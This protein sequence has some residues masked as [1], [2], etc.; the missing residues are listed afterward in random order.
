[1]MV[2]AGFISSEKDVQQAYGAVLEASQNNWNGKIGNDMECCIYAYENLEETLKE[3]FLDICVFCQGRDWE[4]L[5][6]IVGE[7]ELKMLEDRALV[8][9]DVKSMTVRV[10]DVMLAIGLDKKGERF[11][12]TRASDFEKFSKK[13]NDQ[14]QKIKGIWSSDDSNLLYVPASKLD[15]MHRSLRVVILAE[16]T[17]VAGKCT[18]IFKELVIF[19]EILIFLLISQS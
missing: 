16:S 15:S 14:L 13:D 8:T 5:S 17:K 12:F 2:V 11:R 1:M 19:R 10:H 18:E 6:K 9:K 4:T 3:I 7:A